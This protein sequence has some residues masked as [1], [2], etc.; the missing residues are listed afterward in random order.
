MGQYALLLC[1]AVAG[2][3]AKVED[4]G[5]A[6]PLVASGFY[7]CVCGDRMAAVGTFREMIFFSA[8][9]VYCTAIIIYS[10]TYDPVPATA[11]PQK[12]PE[13]WGPRLW[14]HSWDFRIAASALVDDSSSLEVHRTCLSR[15][16][17]FTV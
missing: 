1:F 6:S 3:V 2:Q 15:L 8:E 12:L 4:K 11:T 5:D 9:P 17:P 16:K 10:R 13:A 14:S 7:D